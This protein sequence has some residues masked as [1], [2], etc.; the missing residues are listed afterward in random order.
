MAKNYKVLERDNLN[1]V[2]N[3]Y[4]TTPNGSKSYRYQYDSLGNIIYR[5]D[6]GNY[7]YDTSSDKSRK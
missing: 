3:E 1:R 5:S 6:V 2:T 7:E 4:V